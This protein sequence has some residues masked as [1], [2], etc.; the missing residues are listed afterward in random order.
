MGKP[1]QKSL[2]FNHWESK[3]SKHYFISLSKRPKQ[4]LFFNIFWVNQYLTPMQATS[5][6]KLLGIPWREDVKL[7][8][9][10]IFFFK[11]TYPWK[12]HW[13][14]CLGPVSGD[15]TCHPRSGF[16]HLTR[17]YKKIIENHLP[18]TKMPWLRFRL[19][20][21]PFQNHPGRVPQRPAH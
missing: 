20:W 6:R 13:V 1:T 11:K 9:F 19:Q 4:A 15:R 14:W 8:I 12:F 3:L 5:R 7:Y 16:H 10:F 21:S 18:C 2:E 17:K